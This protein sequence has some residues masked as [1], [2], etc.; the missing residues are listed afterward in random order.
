VGYVRRALNL[1]FL[2]PKIVEAIAAGNHRIWRP[3]KK[4]RLGAGPISTFGTYGYRV[5][6]RR[7]SAVLPDRCRFLWAEHQVRRH[8][9]TRGV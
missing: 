2:A 6:S 3:D 7:R 9:S 5:S 4:N 1:A 8:A